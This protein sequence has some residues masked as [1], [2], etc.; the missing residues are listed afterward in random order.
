MM[1]IK[2]VIA[3]CCGRM[4]RAIADCAVRD[5]RFSLGAVFEAPGHQAVGREYGAVLGRPDAL[6]VRVGDDAGA[7]IRQGEVLVEFT[8]PQATVAHV[9]MA[10]QRRMPAVVGTTG[11]STTQLAALR[12]ASHR[13]PIVVSPNMSIGVTVLF[14]L[15]R[16]AAERLGSGYDVEI[17]ESHHKHK[18]D[19]PSGTAKRLATLLE[20]VRRQRSGSLPIHAIRAGEIVGDHTVVFAGSSERLELTHRAQHRDV[21]AQGALR[22]AAFVHRR[23]PGLYEMTDVLRMSATSDR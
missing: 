17:V 23:R 3:G 21:F 4:G 8:T 14:E 13:I 22:A 1:T 7:A 20:S 15:A 10:Q 19:A 5:A 16:L 9:R 18:Q 11:L 6:G 2:L 12:Q